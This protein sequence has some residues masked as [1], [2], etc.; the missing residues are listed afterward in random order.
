[1]IVVID[2]FI[3]HQWLL[4]EIEQNL[5][6]MFQDPGVY[7]WWEGWWARDPVNTTQR[8]IH[9]VWVEECPI[10]DTFQISGVE[11]WTGRQ[12]C[13]ETDKRWEDNLIMHIDKDEEHWDNTDEVIGPVMGTIYYPPG[14]D[15]DGGNLEIF[16]DGS[17]NPPE[18]LKA[19]DNRLIIF[20]AGKYYH[21]VSQVTRGSR[22]AIAF[23]LWDAPPSG[24]A[25]GAL[26]QE[27]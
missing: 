9:Y 4:D 17:D 5:D 2:N 15:F 3:K 10:R 13:A 1:M 26:V 18:V 6:D 25:S 7:K 16:T 27:Y 20:E 22:R 12:T 21:R 19:K 8:L 14:Q 11:Y 24:V 23:N